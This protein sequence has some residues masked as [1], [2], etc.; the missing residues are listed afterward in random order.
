MSSSYSIEFKLKC[1]ARSVYLF[2]WV[3]FL[4]LSNCVR[5][6]I[7]LLF[8]SYNNK[9]SLYTCKPPWPLLFI[10]FIPYS[11]CCC[12]KNGLPIFIQ[13]SVK[14]TIVQGRKEIITCVCVFISCWCFTNLSFVFRFEKWLNWLI[15][16]HVCVRVCL[17][18]SECDAK[19]LM[20]FFLSPS[21]YSSFLFTHTK[22]YW[23]M[24]SNIKIRKNKH[25]I[26]YTQR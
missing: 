8:V 13:H 12:S 21:S 16:F 6:S 19:N 14:E 15:V 3:V 25:Q 7:L 11:C 22:H 5:Y 17:C 26:K 1:E 23:Q 4:F 10:L 24:G 20:F 2:F 18:V 9:C